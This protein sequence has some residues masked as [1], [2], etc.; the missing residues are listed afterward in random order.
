MDTVE[1]ILA[2]DINLINMANTFIKLQMDFIFSIRIYCMKKWYTKY[3]VF[4]YK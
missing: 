4:A 1:D 3:F 2:I